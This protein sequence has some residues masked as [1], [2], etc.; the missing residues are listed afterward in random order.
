MN[1]R[2]GLA[3]LV[4]CGAAACANGDERQSGSIDL[5]AAALSSMTVA[6]PE[7]QPSQALT[8]DGKPWKFVIAPYLWIPA[9]HG[10]IGIR[11]LNANVSMTVGDTWNALW[12]N[13]RF[14]GCLHMEAVKDR[15][16]IFGDVMYMHL[17]NDVK[18]LP[19]N[20]DYKQGIF[21]LGGSYAIHDG[22]LPGAAADS[23][24]RVRIEPL[25]GVRLWY[26]DATIQTPIGS[27]GVDETWVDGFGGIRG[28]LAFNETFS[29]T[30]RVDIGAGMS[31]MTW[32]ALTMVNVNLNEHWAI[33]AGWRWLSDN[34]SKGSG[35]DRFAYDMMFN[36]PFAGVKITF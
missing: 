1:R 24:V 28:E 34:Y 35:A 27:R 18:G 25:V 12:D 33:F 10:T 14:A 30:G 4:T 8:V 13:F 6:E 32:N 17:G 26:L 19:V 5:S 3:L 15:W 23:T 2:I 31:D 20:V 29:L 11:R 7:S 16:S 22:P 21:E 9:Q 36:G